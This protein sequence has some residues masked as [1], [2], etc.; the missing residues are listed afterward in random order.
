MHLPAIY[1]PAQKI[2]VEPNT[3][4]RLISSS[5]PMNNALKK[6]LEGI[7]T[8]SVKRFQNKCRKPSNPPV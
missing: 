5:A 6:K 8:T 7:L 4:T 1:I 2:S 3:S